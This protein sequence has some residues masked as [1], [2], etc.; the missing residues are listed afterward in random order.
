[1]LIQ[2]ARARIGEGDYIGGRADLDDV[3]KGSPSS[4]RKKRPG[5]PK[6]RLEQIIEDLTKQLQQ[7]MSTSQRMLAEQLRDDMNKQIRQAGKQW[8]IPWPVDSE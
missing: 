7:N 8:H 5:L 6:G 3:A 2:R 1:M 4:K